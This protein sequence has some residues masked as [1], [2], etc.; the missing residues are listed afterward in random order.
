M[1]WNHALV[2]RQVYRRATAPPP[3]KWGVLVKWST[4]YPD[5]SS[6]EKARTSVGRPGL[7]FLE[8]RALLHEA[9]HELVERLAR[10]A[11]LVFGKLRQRRV[12]QVQRLG[13]RHAW[14]FIVDQAGQEDLIHLRFF[15]QRQRSQTIA[16]VVILAQ[17]LQ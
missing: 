8:D 11:Q 15:Q 4:I 10:R 6:N 3:S 9:L 13:Q 14:L 17:F 12:R 5:D 16:R 7:A 2:L 1:I